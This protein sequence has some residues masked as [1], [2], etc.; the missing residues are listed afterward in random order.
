VLINQ[1]WEESVDIAKPFEISK[2]LVWDAWKKIKANG[3]TYGVDFQSIEA[4]EED[5]AGNLYKLWNR[6][7]SGSYFP[8]PVRRVE[9]PKGKDGKRPLGIPT[10]ADRTA[11]MVVKMLLEPEIEP[12]FHPDSSGYRPKKSAIDAVGTARKRCWRYDWVVDL[13]IKGFFD[14]IDHELMMRAVK[15]HTRCKWIQLYIERWLKA[16]VQM[17]DGTLVQ[18]EKGTPQ[19]GVASP[20]LANLFLHYAFDLWMERENPG[21]PFERYADDC[22]IHCRTKAEAET[23]KGAV[24]ARLAECKLEA[25]PEKTRIAYCK[26]SKRKGGYPN[27]SFDFLGFTFRPREVWTNGRRFTGFNPAISNKARKKIGDRIRGW[28]IQKWTRYSIEEVAKALNPIISGWLNYYGSFFRS[29]MYRIAD[30][31][32]FALVRWAR[33]KFK[34]LTRSYRKS[35]AFIKRIKSQ[36]PRL[37]AHWRLRSLP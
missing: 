32:N 34:K 14:E 4:F 18:R 25:H 28:K 31:L 8:P 6:M 24:S 36:N 27:I 33:K 29:E 13:D 2:R 19:G 5:L 11:Q 7:S 30:A 3:G 10:V 20:L 16:P 17:E 9:I 15:K 21:V 12:I 35:T 22:L 1:Q 37:F 23:V 26:D